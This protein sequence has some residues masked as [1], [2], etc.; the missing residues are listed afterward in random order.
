ML[1]KMINSVV[2]MKTE[3]FWSTKLCQLLWRSLLLPSLGFRPA[4]TQRME[5]ASSAEALVTV[6]PIDMVSYLRGCESMSTP[7]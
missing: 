2:E 7:L 5:A 3:V 6:S 4:C 1:G